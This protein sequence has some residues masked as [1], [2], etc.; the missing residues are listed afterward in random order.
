MKNWFKR[1]SNWIGLSGGAEEE[2]TTMSTVPYNQRMYFIRKAVEK[3]FNVD[4]MPVMGDD[5]D[6]ISWAVR[7]KRYCKCGN[8]WLPWIPSVQSYTEFL[9]ARFNSDFES[10]EDAME[11]KIAVNVRAYQET[12]LCEYLT[13]SRISLSRGIYDEAGGVTARIYFV[14]YDAGAERT[15][16]LG[17]FCSEFAR[18]FT[19]NYTEISNETD[20]N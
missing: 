10:L 3:T 19:R 9:Y 1:F 8:Y 4:S 16:I 13:L 6:W 14:S 5:A 11:V 20:T 15:S 12:V 18:E 7:G 2:Q 17:Q